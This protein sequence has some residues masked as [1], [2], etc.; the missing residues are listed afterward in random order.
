MNKISSFK[1]S[2]LFSAIKVSFWTGSSRVLGLLR[3]IS[4]T[5]LFGAPKRFVV[6]ISLNSPKTL[7]LPVQKL[8]FIA[9]KR[10][11]ILNELILFIKI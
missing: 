3:D 4:T 5:N 8:T 10:L 11:E 7:E 9:E 6:E 1:I 2:N